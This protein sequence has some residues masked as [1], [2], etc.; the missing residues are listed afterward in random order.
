M[1]R[2][3]DAAAND[4]KERKDA[5]LT[6]AEERARH[7]ILCWQVLRSIREFRN[8]VIDDTNAWILSVANDLHVCVHAAS[9]GPILWEFDENE[10]EG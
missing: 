6:L 10:V 2:V 3:C 8:A 5:I 4:V 9:P 7:K 1:K